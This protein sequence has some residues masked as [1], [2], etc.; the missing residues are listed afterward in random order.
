MLTLLGAAFIYFSS[1]PFWERLS[2]TPNIFG[3]ALN[4]DFFASSILFGEEYIFG[5]NENLPIDYFLEKVSNHRQSSE[6]EFM[7]VPVFQKIAILLLSLLEF[8]LLASS[9]GRNCYK[10]T[11]SLKKKKKHPSPANRPTVDPFWGTPLPTRGSGLC[12]TDDTGGTC[13]IF[14]CSR[15]RGG[16]E[17]QGSGRLKSLD[18]HGKA[19]K[20]HPKTPPKTMKTMFERKKHPEKHQKSQQRK[21]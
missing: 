7:S 15:T 16:G 2:Q 3:K 4:H 21:T 17:K 14:L 19:L 11:C 20:K 1:N 9:K 12:P 18:N 5:R 10:K 6:H 8:F 13:R